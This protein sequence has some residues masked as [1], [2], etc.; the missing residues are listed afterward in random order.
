VVE[1]TATADSAG[2]A[3]LNTAFVRAG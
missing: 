2:P 3:S 1:L